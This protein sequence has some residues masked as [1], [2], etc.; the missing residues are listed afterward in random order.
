MSQKQA[1]SP[2]SVQVGGGHYKNAKI[3]PAHFWL[4]NQLPGAESSVIKYVFRWQSKDGIRDLKKSRH[5]IQLM[6]DAYFGP[7][8]FASPRVA[9]ADFQWAITPE[10]FCTENGLDVAASRVICLVCHCESEAALLLAIR[11]I[12]AMIDAHMSAQPEMD[13]RTTQELSVGSSC[14]DTLRAQQAIYV[15]INRL[16]DFD[17]VLREPGRINA[18]Y[19]EYERERVSRTLAYLRDE[20]RA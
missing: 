8:A 7:S 15:A 17:E 13:G 12:N 5:F 9:N 1:D 14:A 6:I 16:E 4:A 3:Q 2:W 19:V 18:A 10:H 11:T 20:A